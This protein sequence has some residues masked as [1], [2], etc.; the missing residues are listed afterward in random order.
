MAALDEIESVAYRLEGTP[1]ATTLV[2]LPKEITLGRGLPRPALGVYA[3]G[4]GDLKFQLGVQHVRRWLND[5]WARSGATSSRSATS[6]SP[7]ELLPAVRR[8]A[9]VLCRTRAV[10]RAD[11]RGPV[12]RWRPRRDG[13]VRG[14]GWPRRPRL[15]PALRAIA[16]RL[17]GKRPARPASRRVPRTCPRSTPTTPVLRSPL[18]T[19]RATRRHSRPAACRRHQLRAHGRHARGGSRLGTP[20]GRRAQGNPA[21]QEPHVGQPGGRHRP[22]RRPSGRSGILARRPARLPSIQLDELRVA[23]YW[24]A[25]ASFLRR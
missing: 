3:D 7:D 8:G 13:R 11:P 4:G 20:R 17:L 18:A 15:E 22:R 23:Q 2:W 1:D 16:P 25:E 12:D 5:R 21:P 24:L 19:T 14:Y 9:A 6:R 10:R